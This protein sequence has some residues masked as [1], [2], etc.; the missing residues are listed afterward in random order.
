MLLKSITCKTI[1]AECVVCVCGERPQELS[2]LQIYSTTFYIVTK[3][4]N[5]CCSGLS[6][7]FLENKQ[8]PLHRWTVPY[9]LGFSEDMV[10]SW[11]DKENRLYLSEHMWMNKEINLNN[12][13]KIYLFIL[14]SVKTLKYSSVRP[15]GGCCIITPTMFSARANEI[16]T[17]RNT[18]SQLF[19]AQFL[20][21][22]VHSLH[23]STG[24]D[25]NR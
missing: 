18:E 23:I 15:E 13:N 9:L 2:L 7:C 10:S 8:R 22:G 17:Q 24:L 20:F 11:G 5:R 4:P 25:G 6:E 19:Y 3:Q 12:M 21:G 14:N 16:F 1:P